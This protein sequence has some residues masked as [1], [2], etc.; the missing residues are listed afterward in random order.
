MMEGY[1]GIIS[2]PVCA[3]CTSEAVVV[4]TVHARATTKSFLHLWLRAGTACEI[5]ITADRSEVGRRSGEV[6][7]KRVAI[8]PVSCGV[9]VIRGGLE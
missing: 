4:S 8:T 2:G 3:G 9:V 5:G 6:V 1:P 7:V